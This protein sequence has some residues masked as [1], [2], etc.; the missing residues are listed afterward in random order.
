[1]ERLQQ[2]FPAL[3]IIRNAENLGFPAGNNIGI[4]DALS[5]DPNYL[6]LLNND[7]IVAADFLEQLVRVAERDA[8][9]GL[10]NPKI[11]YQE[12]ANRI[13]YAGGS[14][15]GG[16]S[17]AR[18]FGVNR[19]DN[20][21]YNQVTDVSFVTGCALLA[22]TDVVRK[23]GLLDEA[24]FLGFEDLDWCIRARDAGFRAV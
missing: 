16:R 19:I 21:K 7:T 23:V 13:W 17:F 1:R 2:E 10:V 18:H 24:F 8:G 22:K 20:G 14:Y 9:I 6:L 4:R 11:L 12:P 15:R 3:R 5:R